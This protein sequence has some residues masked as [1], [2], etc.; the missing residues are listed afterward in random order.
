MSSKAIFLAGLLG[1]ALLSA[2]SLFVGV[3]DLSVDTLFK[4][5][6]ALELIVISRFPRTAA[7]LIAG[8]TLAISGAIMQMLVRNRFVEPMTAGTGQ[9]AALG[10]LIVILFLPGASIL[11]KMIVA[12]WCLWSQ[13]SAFLPSCESSR[14]PNRSSCPSWG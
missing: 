1:L 8:A 11:T 6:E 4:D 9:G 3:I 2:L 5:P 10:L 7:A 12:L 13:A 14:R